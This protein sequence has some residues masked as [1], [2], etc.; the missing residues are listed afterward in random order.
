MGD[1][2]SADVHELRATMRRNLGTDHVLS[3]V[4]ARKYIHL[5]PIR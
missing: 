1:Q 2:S 3:S 4:P 5:D